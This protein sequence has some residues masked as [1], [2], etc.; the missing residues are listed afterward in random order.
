MHQ[1]VVVVHCRCLTQS[2]ALVEFKYSPLLHG[3][4]SL[5]WF[6]GINR[7][8]NTQHTKKVEQNFKHDSSSLLNRRMTKFYDF[9]GALSR[10]TY[11]TTVKGNEEENSVLCEPEAFR[12]REKRGGE[13]RRVIRNYLGEE[14]K[15]SLSKNFLVSFPLL[16]V[17]Y[18]NFTHMR[19]RS[20]PGAL[21]TL[22]ISLAL[23]QKTGTNTTTNSMNQ[24]QGEGSSRRESVSKEITSSAIMGRKISREALR[25][26]IF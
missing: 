15:F 7:E 13:E 4:I 8:N 2:Q 26:R 11:C 24:V 3:S 21:Y 9:I 10:H 18:Q 20:M 22:Q 5:N 12:E 19:S 6:E 1:H 14:K 25:I 17:V 16:F 23:E